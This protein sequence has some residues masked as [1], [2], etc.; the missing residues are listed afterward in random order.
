MSLK[1]AW[2]NKINIINVF[3]E[4]FIEEK[5]IALQPISFIFEEVSNINKEEKLKGKNSTS[6]DLQTK[7]KKLEKDRNSQKTKETSKLKKIESPKRKS[8]NNSDLYSSNI[9]IV[10]DNGSRDSSFNMIE[11]EVEKLNKLMSKSRSKKNKK[12]SNK[13]DIKQPNSAKY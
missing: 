8:I 4:K 5:D 6:N 3:D 13:K 12:R 2:R 1:C 10:T 11:K 9:V 7:N